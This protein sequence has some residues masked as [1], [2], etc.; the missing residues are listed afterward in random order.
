MSQEYNEQIHRRFYE[1]VVNQ[2]KLNLIDEWF[3]WNYTSRALHPCFPPGR[4]GLKAFV[5]AFH[6]AFPDAWV[7]VDHLSADGNESIARITFR[8]T[9]MAQ[10]HGVTPLGQAV[11]IHTI[12]IARFD[13]GKCVEQW[14]G[15][16][17]FN[18][19]YHLNTAAASRTPTP[20]I[21]LAQPA[22]FPRARVLD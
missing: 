6:A 9:P 18:L 20:P 1:E 5:R 12:D 13:D 14:G 2:C 17:I 22:K 10:F 7:T 19:S 15:L 16:N 3:A 8:G 4:E 11:V 21:H